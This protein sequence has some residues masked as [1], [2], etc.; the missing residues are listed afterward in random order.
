MKRLLCQNSRAWACGS[1]LGRDI[2]Y[3]DLLAS[4]SHLLFLLLT[5]LLFSISPSHTL[6]WVAPYFKRHISGKHASLFFF[7][8]LVPQAW[9]FSLF[10]SRKR[11]TATPAF[12]TIIHRWHLG[13]RIPLPILW[14]FLSMPFIPDIVCLE[15]NIITIWSFLN[16]SC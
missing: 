5:F 11:M 13:P 12:N 3:G 9:L 4:L 15:L 8:L 10:L 16:S 6:T 1:S 7:L 14:T 2:S